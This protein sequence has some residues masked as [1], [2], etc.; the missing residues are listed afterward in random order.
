MMLPC[1]KLALL[2]LM[3]NIFGLTNEVKH[4]FKKK[5]HHLTIQGEFPHVS[6]FQFNC[7]YYM[8]SDHLVLKMRVGGKQSDW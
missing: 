3:K 7:F 5:K 2:F 4:S 8:L 1:S 6:T